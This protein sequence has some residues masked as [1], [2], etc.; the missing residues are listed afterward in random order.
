MTQFPVCIEIHKKWQNIS[1]QFKWV[2]FQQTQ[3]MRSDE[4]RIAMKSGHHLQPAGRIFTILFWW[5]LQLEKKTVDD[6]KFC[7]QRDNCFSWRSSI[8]F[9]SACSKTWTDTI[10]LIFPPLRHR[11][12]FREKPP[13]R[14]ARRQ[15]LN[16]TKLT[17]KSVTI[18]F[19]ANF[20]QVPISE[21]RRKSRANLRF[22]SLAVTISEDVPLKNFQICEKSTWSRIWK[23][24]AIQ[25][26]REYVKC[27]FLMQFA[28][29]SG[30]KNWEIIW[31]VKSVSNFCFRVLIRMRSKFKIARK[32]LEKS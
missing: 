22:V 12:N 24:A 8:F 1:L 19:S 7:I 2:S 13:K 9:R 14:A 18:F 28:S 20:L 15:K 23:F 16:A 32:K 31:R 26:G 3:I 25:G 30:G 4:T 11:E 27:D 21:R 6:K 5:K 10:F 29:D 17:N